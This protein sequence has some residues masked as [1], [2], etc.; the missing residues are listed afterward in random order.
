MKLTA[1][2]LSLFSS[3]AQRFLE[4]LERARPPSKRAVA[5]KL[6]AAGQPMPDAVIDFEVQ[7]GG[8]VFGPPGNRSDVKLGIEYRPRRRLSSQP[9]D[10]ELTSVPIG[11]AH[12]EYDLLYMNE[13][14]EVIAYVD[15]VVMKNSSITSYIEQELISYTRAWRR[16]SFYAGVWPAMGVRLADAMGLH[17][18]PLVSDAY[19]AWW[20]GDGVRLT[21]VLFPGSWASGHTSVMARSLEHLVR[22][23]RAARSLD[24]ALRV[25][26]NAEPRKEVRPRKRQRDSA[27]PME[28]WAEVP[29]AERYAFGSTGAGTG[30]VWVVPG[31][32]GHRIQQYR[33]FNYP[34]LPSELAAWTTLTSKGAI[35]RNMEEWLA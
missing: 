24:P 1:K 35:V 31:R 9:D 16:P 7:F 25:S 3:P 17:G 19:E 13:E 8:L 32:R 12:D 28:S 18:I 5:E 10:P 34:G 6:R 21:Q 14:G 30:A 29:G 23:L 20:E 15:S 26:V 22:A 4:R 27:P 2:T 11:L 33:I